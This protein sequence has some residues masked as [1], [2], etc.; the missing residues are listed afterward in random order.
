MNDGWTWARLDRERLQ[1]I[2]EAEQTLGSDILL[3]Y[4]PGDQAS[5]QEETISQ[6]GV[7]VAPLDES[8]LECLQGL[9]EKVSAVVVAYQRAGKT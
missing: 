6:M 4:Q 8:Q 5:L 1:M 7:K 2:R 9:E 3:A